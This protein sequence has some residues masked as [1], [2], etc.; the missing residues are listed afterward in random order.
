MILGKTLYCDLPGPPDPAL[1]E[2]ATVSV[3]QSKVLVPPPVATP[4]GALWVALWVG[5]ASTATRKVFRAARA[6]RRSLSG[7]AA[8]PRSPAELLA[9]AHDV[10][11]ES[12]SLAAELRA[13]ALQ[14]LAV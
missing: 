2:E 8:A 3:Q 9:L 13:F 6:G 1:E 7:R 4:R 5:A 12:P 11:T 14:R 10:E